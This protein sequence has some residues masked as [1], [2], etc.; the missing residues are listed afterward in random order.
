MADSVH[1]HC[2]DLQGMLR[3]AAADALGMG[4]VLNY[5]E[6]REELIERE[7][8]GSGRQREVWLECDHRERRLDLTIQL[9]QFEQD[10]KEVC[11]R[12]SGEPASGHVSSIICCKWSNGWSVIMCTSVRA[13]STNDIYQFCRMIFFTQT[14]N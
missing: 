8:R 14:D 13:F 9:N 3:S 7:E 12:R 4:V 5:V 10:L 6:A 11:M 1:Q 2:V